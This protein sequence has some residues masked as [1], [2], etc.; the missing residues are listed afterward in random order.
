M[1]WIDAFHCFRRERVVAN[2][3]KSDWSPVVSGVPEGIFLGPLLFYLHINDFASDIESKIRL[4]AVECVSYR[5]IK[6]K[7]DTL[8]L[9]KDIDRLGSWVMRFQPVKC[10]MMQLTKKLNTIQAS[11]ALYRG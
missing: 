4:F 11:Y 8:K 10:N 3:I 7:E 2:G 9:Q 6:N 5:E 1:K